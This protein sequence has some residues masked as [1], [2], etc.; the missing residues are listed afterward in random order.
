MLQS[1]KSQ[2]IKHDFLTEQQQILYSE[3]FF[4]FFASAPFVS[5]HPILDITLHLV[6]TNTGQIFFRMSPRWYLSDFSETGVM[7]LWEEGQR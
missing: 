3:F 1:V 5:H 6:I 7:S 4:F 2:R